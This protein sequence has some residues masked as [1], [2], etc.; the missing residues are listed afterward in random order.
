MLCQS[1]G[2]E[3]HAEALYCQHCGTRINK[4]C[5]R[6]AEIVKLKAKICRFCRYEFMTKDF[7]EIEAKEQSRLKRL[8]SER[9]A[10]EEKE[11]AR[12]HP[13]HIVS[14]WGAKLLKCAQCGTLNSFSVAECRRCRNPLQSANLI[15]NP[16]S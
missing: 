8:E 5:P 6:C 15:D 16:Y 4:E 10:N 11:F 7:A 9:I 12:F 14:T 2:I 13:P 3:T 1:C